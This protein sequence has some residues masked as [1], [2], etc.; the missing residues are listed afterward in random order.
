MIEGMTS[1]LAMKSV[2]R[3]LLVAIPSWLVWA[4]IIVH[5]APGAPNGVERAVF[6]LTTVAAFIGCLWACWFAL[7]QH[8]GKAWHRVAT[9]GIG[10]IVFV[11]VIFVGHTLGIALASQFAPRSL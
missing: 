5:A 10:I 3:I 7:P 9:L 4:A 1:E 6:G 11:L 8:A 2:K